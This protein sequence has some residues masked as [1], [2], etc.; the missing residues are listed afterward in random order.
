MTQR[1]ERRTSGPVFFGFF[2]AWGAVVAIGLTS[3][4]TRTILIASLLTL[5]IPGVAIVLLSIWRS[6]VDRRELPRMLTDI[7]RVHPG[8]RLS[9]AFYPLGAVIAG[10][11]VF[12]F[13]LYLPFLACY[14]AVRVLLCRALGRPLPHER[15]QDRRPP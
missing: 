4:G 13:M 3:A 14:G 11:F 9:G 1:C 15:A 2:A 8:T 6:P 10:A 5:Y 12:A 7:Y